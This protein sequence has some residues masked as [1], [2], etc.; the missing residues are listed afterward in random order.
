[1][2]MNSVNSLLYTYLDVQ[3]LVVQ[4]G[5]KGSDSH[6]KWESIAKPKS[7]GGWGIKNLPLFSKAL[8]A[9]TLW[10]N[11]M[12]DGLWH[13]VLLDKYL[14]SLTVEAWLRST[15]KL[16]RNVSIFWRCLVKSVEVITH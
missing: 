9:N 3:L 8:V 16:S 10:H 2:H 13:R 6:C 7:Q 5:D 4:E 11:L 15:T 14:P 1:V 12:E